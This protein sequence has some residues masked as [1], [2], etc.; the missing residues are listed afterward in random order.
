MIAP[1]GIGAAHQRRE[2]GKPRKA[3]GAGRLHQLS[4]PK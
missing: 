2:F 4:S 1:F 3:S